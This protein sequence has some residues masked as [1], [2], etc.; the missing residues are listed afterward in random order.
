[1]LS[2]TIYLSHQSS[3]PTPAFFSQGIYLHISLLRV[4]G[5]SC[6]PVRSLGSLPSPLWS[7][8]AHH[9]GPGC[10]SSH[11][12]SSSQFR[13]SSVYRFS[14]PCPSSCYTRRLSSFP[15]SFYFSPSLWFSPP[16]CLVAFPVLAIPP[17]LAVSQGQSS[18]WPCGG[19]RTPPM[20]THGSGLVSSRTHNVQ[21]LS[22]SS[23][24]T[25]RCT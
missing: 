18:A 2:T 22:P 20:P 1:M 15:P 14:S 7:S 6:R 9:S 3:A 17:V 24:S 10:I 4:A 8:L 16:S 25:R 12:R 19:G 23:S 11:C 13:F 5:P 21:P